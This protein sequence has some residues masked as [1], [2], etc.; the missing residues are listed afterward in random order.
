[1]SNRKA[2]HKF[3][4]SYRLFSFLQRSMSRIEAIMDLVD[5]MHISGLIGQ[6]ER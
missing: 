2:K 6:K 1:M 5:E 3:L 4:T